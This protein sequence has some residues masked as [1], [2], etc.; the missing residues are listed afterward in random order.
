[1]TDHTNILNEQMAIAIPITTTDRSQ[2]KTFAEQQPTQPKAEQVYRNTIAV[3]VTHHCLQLLGIRSNLEMSN[4]WNPLHRQLENVADL[5]V[6]TG[7][8][9]L[10]CCSIRPEENQ[11]F[12]SEASRSDRIG[13]VVVQ[14]DEAYRQGQVLGFAASLSSNHL[15]L[16][17]LQ[18]LDALID[19]LAAMPIHLEA[20]LQHQFDRGWELCDPIA[21]LEKPAILPLAGA[22]R[23]GWH[24]QDQV[25]R[26]VEQLCHKQ[27]VIPSSPAIEPEAAL[28]QLIQSADDEIRWQAAELL[29]QL[30]PQHSA[31]PVISAK[32]LG[33]YLKGHRV[34]LVIGVLPKTDGSRLT[35]LRL[36]P[37]EPE[38]HLPPSLKLIGLD[39]A[40]N[41][42][43][44]V[45]SRA[46]DDYIQ[47]KFT[48]EVGDRF[49][50]R[51]VLNEATFTERFVV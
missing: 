29:W 19:Y 11:C 41:Q 10:E 38:F 49:T 48:A 16:S 37:L 35:L 32:D 50:L 22:L 17:E 7:E 20:W 12:I 40:G 21:Q 8:G 30:N 46:Q 42:L 9:R 51:V 23:G 27:A 26:Q 24:R 43:F 31:C 47:F 1:M 33:L 6:P 3:L 44:Q 25:K 2:A 5:Y 13:Y 45:E 36:Y 18:P 15:A 4:S 39:E 28:V 14:I 34:A